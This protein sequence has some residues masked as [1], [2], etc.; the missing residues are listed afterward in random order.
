MIKPLGFKITAVFLSVLLTI[1][2]F[3]TDVKAMGLLLSG[4]RGSP[5][6]EVQK[7]L[8]QL[9]Y[10]RTRPTG[11][12]GKLTKEAVKAFQIEHN[13]IVD[14]VV[15]PVTINALR[16]VINDRNKIVEYTVKPSD[17]L[18]KIAVQYRTDVAVIMARNNLPDKRIVE[19]QKLYIP[20][21]V[22]PVA[23]QN[24]RNRPGGIQAIPW[25]IVN[26]LWRNGE[27]AKI[28]DLETGKSFQAKRLYGYY[29]ADVEPLTKE[30]TKIMKEIY[31][32]RWSWERRAVVAQ[33]RNLF[34]AAS[35]NGM[36]H[37]GESIYNND[38]KG[39]F[40]AHFL[41]SRV[42]QTG[43]VD[44]MHHAMIERAKGS[45]LFGVGKVEREIVPIPVITETGVESF[46][47]DF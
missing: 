24:S 46:I 14:G 8:V 15:G 31:G 47:P 23:N 44:R 10:L 19:G 41:G 26:Q 7:Y 42:H 5:V 45:S 37:G 16:E 39:Q 13:L 38:F 33:V 6:V 20:T 34:V 18:E 35:I 9:N 30:D 11:Y 40:C 21:G 29:H 12:Y 27:V 1:G 4:S 2:F 17:E 25:S 36:P 43:G 28:L 3:A 32:G 22:N